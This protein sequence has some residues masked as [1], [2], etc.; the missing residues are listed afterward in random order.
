MPHAGAAALS[1]MTLVLN[2]IYFVFLLFFLS[3]VYI[4]CCSVKFVMNKDVHS[5]ALYSLEMPG[6]FSN[7]TVTIFRLGKF[8]NKKAMVLKNSGQVLKKILSSHGILPRL[9]VFNQ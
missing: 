8:W 5:Q 4:Q 6:K 3:S 2:S 1:V 7:L 9:I